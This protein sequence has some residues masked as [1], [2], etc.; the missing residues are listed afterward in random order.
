[1]YP[2]HA[3]HMH[4]HSDIHACMHI[5]HMQEN[6]HADIGSVY[7]VKFRK[8]M[9]L[10]TWTLIHRNSPTCMH[11]MA[12]VLTYLNMPYICVSPGISRHVRNMSHVYTHTKCAHIWSK[13]PNRSYM[14]PFLLYDLEFWNSSVW[15]AL[16]SIFPD[17]IFSWHTALVKRL[18]PT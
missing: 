7:R 8:H 5:C 1:M 12:Y 14:C 15:F 10:P 6:V 3:H 11:P 13:H 9:F 17:L 2:H 16:P 18:F 4:L